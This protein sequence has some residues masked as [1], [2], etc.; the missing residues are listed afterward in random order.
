MNIKEEHYKN[1]L[2]FYPPFTLLFPYPE[3][4]TGNIIHATCIQTCLQ[5]LGQ[6]IFRI[7]L[8]DLFNFSM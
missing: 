6:R 4:Q 8:Q 3:V 7:V 2:H 5:E 1:I